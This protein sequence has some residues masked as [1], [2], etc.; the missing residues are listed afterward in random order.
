MASTQFALSP[1]IKS[2]PLDAEKVRASWVQRFD[3]ASGYPYYENTYSG[4]TT[5]ERPAVLDEGVR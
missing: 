3:P 5:W 4:E 1:P 2:A